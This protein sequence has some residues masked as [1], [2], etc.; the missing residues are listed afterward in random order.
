MEGAKGGGEITLRWTPPGG[1][2]QEKKVVVK[3][4][5]VSVILGGE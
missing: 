3:G 2:A 1:K 5:P 4:E